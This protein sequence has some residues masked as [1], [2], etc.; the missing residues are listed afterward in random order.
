MTTP[1]RSQSTLIDISRSRTLFLVLFFGLWSLAV[2]A[3]LAQIM[4]VNRRHYLLEMGRSS[5]HQ[6]ILPAIRGRILDVDGRPL[7]WSSRHF[8][9]K[10]QIPQNTAV[11]QQQW[12]ALTTLVHV[13]PKTWSLNNMLTRSGETIL[14]HDDLNATQ[15]AKIAPLTEKWNNLYVASRFQR[16][17]YPLHAIRK[18]LGHVQI[19]NGMEI[20]VSGYELAH[21]SLLRGRPGMFRVMLDPEG[22][23]IPSTWEKIRDIKP[24]YDVYVPMRVS[25]LTEETRQ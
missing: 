25:P 23:W 13:L 14:L 20:G 2:T 19:V 15:F 5:W 6:G 17:H 12:H 9:C 3:R 10:W 4:V 11:A 7:A 24:G 1:E 16:H 22:R 21:D 8:V 18:R